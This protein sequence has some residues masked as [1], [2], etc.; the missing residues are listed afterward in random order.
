MHMSIIIRGIVMDFRISRKWFGIE[1]Q[2]PWKFKDV[3]VVFLISCISIPLLLILSRLF[4]IIT[5]LFVGNF[6]YI[7]GFTF[8]FVPII[9]IKKSYSAKMQTLGVRRGRWPI[10]YIIAVGIGGGI[11]FHLVASAI[12]GFQLKTGEFGIEN[13]WSFILAKLTFTGFYLF[14]LGPVS[15]EIF[16]RGFLYGYLRRRL[17]VLF[18]LLIQSAIF[19]LFHLDLEET[20]TGQLPLLIQKVCLGLVLGA[21]YEIS[22]SLY[23]SMICHAIFN[24]LSEGS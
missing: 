18:G 2:V 22:G 12:L 4:F 6:L 10:S 3:L 9:W 20:F 13:I 7:Y 19:S 1:S 16:H 23:P 8:L 15:E 17:G 24:F 5:G 14:F 11:A 21:L